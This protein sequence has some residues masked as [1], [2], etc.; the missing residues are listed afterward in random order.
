MWKVLW[1]AWVE[2]MMKERMLPT[3]PTHPKVVRRTP[4]TM[5]TMTPNPAFLAP[6]GVFAILTGGALGQIS[7]SDVE[8]AIRDEI[9]KA[10]GD[11][12]ASDLAKVKNLRCVKTESLDLVLS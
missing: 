7:D 12:S 11:I 1:T 8:A 3:N 6:L 4:S 9:N 5:K 10:N 2:R